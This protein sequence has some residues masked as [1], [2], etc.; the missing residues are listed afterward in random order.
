MK[1]EYK[2]LTRIERT[3]M[4]R[5]LLAAT[6]ALAFSGVVGA[7]DTSELLRKLQDQIDKLQSEVQILK[8][9]SLDAGGEEGVLGGEDARA[10]GL[11]IGFYGESKYRWQGADGQN[12]GDSHR[13]VLLP[14][15]EIA[16]W[17]IFNSEIEIEHGGVADNSSRFGGKLELE[18]FYLDVLINDH[19]NIRSPGIQLVPLGRVNL[20]HEPTTFYSTDRPKLYRSIIPSTWMETS[21]VGF[22]GEITDG[23]DYQILI[24]TGMDDGF[25]GTS[26]VR[27]SRPD[28]DGKGITD[29]SLAYSG[30]LHYTGIAGLDASASM[31]ATK[32]KSLGAVGGASAVLG[33][34]VEASYRVP[35]TGLELRGD[36]AM[37]H[38]EDP[39]KFA[40][41][42]V[43]KRM[44]GYYAEAAYHFWPEAWN[45]GRGAHMDLVPFV[46]Y[47]NLDFYEGGLEGQATG[48]IR[49]EQYLTLGAAYFLNP[50]VV[51]KA[52]MRRQLH[53]GDNQQYQIAIGM[54]F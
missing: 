35:N 53:L 49:D 3:R 50:N 44:F 25:S 37:W 34:D 16:D 42:N 48:G 12:V 38:F 46:R 39:E 31:Y 13:Y 33:W 52:D 7:Q 22:F 1:T 4:K 8:E 36:F 18:Q 51:F 17:L 9:G 54:F 24:S 45:E 6:L 47:T 23:L 15:Y 20:I 10:K 29:N 27:G 43:G 11:S 41:D 40:A 21:L 14:S 26:G 30:R 19:F 32:V 2:N 28:V 5:T